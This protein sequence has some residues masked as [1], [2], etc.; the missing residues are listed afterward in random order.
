MCE[1][2][3]KTAIVCG[4]SKQQWRGDGSGCGS[5]PLSQ[6]SP[7]ALGRFVCRVLRC[8][9]EQSAVPIARCVNSFAFLPV[10]CWA[11]F[12]AAL[13][14]CEHAFALVSDAAPLSFLSFV[15]ILRPVGSQA[16]GRKTLPSFFVRNRIAWSFVAMSA[17]LRVRA[18][19][20]ERCET[21]ELHAEQMNAN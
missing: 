4:I 16:L 1:P 13:S 11:I 7:T 15:H 10:F 17:A 18:L 3:V 6:D 2:I 14:E 21:K 5:L 8:L 12:F 9:K 20:R 19:R